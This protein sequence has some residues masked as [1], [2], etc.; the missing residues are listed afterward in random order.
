MA[1][2]ELTSKRGLDIPIKGEAS[3]ELNDLTSNVNDVAITPGDF[4]GSLLKPV[5]KPGDYV[6]AGQVVM[7][8]K[9]NEHVKFVS[10][11]SGIV[12]EIRRGKKRKIIAYVIEKDG[13]ERKKKFD[14]TDDLEHV[15]KI[16]IEAGLWASLRQRPFGVFVDPND[17]PDAIFITASDTSPLSPDY[18]FM[19]KDDKDAFSKGIEILSLLGKVNIVAK[20][21]SK[22]F[23]EKFKVENLILVS[24]KHP[25]GNLSYVLQKVNPIN[26]D[27]K[28]WYINPW[29]VV[30]IGR[31]F[32]EGTIDFTKVVALTG[33]S[34]ISPKYYKVISGMPIKTV[35]E[36]NVEKDVE[37][38]FI[39]G[40]VLTGTNV[41]L[42]GFL[43]FYDDMITVLPEGKDY[44]FL[45][46]A[47]P[48]FKKYSP[49]GMF[50]SKLLF[51]SQKRFSFNTNMHGGVRPF[52]LPEISE[53]YVILD[54]LPSFLIKAILVNDIDLM[55]KLG[56]YEVMP[57]D[58]ALMEYACVSKI[59]IQDIIRDGMRKM[60][61][62]S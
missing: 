27:N 31:L 54:V 56:I 26:R 33:P 13:A 62:E 50:F 25:V 1:L 16:L 42:D 24:G 18:E 47:L 17:T 20:K 45:G 2:V 34:V 61:E 39:S 14:I 41:G 30:F 10:P 55:E 28:V 19:L 11:V 3:K 58:F 40:N 29:Q 4:F 38:R 21:K 37:L 9:K 46:W 32:S 5:M 12:K 52:V 57:E 44:E 36:N 43:G 6:E 23:F 35:V 59:N 15:K 8:D 49:S 60:I 51:S 53:K 7:F 48:G 22:D